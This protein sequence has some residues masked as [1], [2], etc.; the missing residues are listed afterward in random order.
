M[1]VRTL[2]LAGA[3]APLM[4][5]CGWFH[6][7]PAPADIDAAVRQA[8]DAEN[9]GPVN[10]FF[11]RPL[12][13]AADIASIGQDGPCRKTAEHAYTCEVVITWHSGKADDASSSRASLVF[14]K[15]G[16]DEWQTYGVD[17]AIVAGAAHAMVD[18]IRRALPGGAASEGRASDAS[19]R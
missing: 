1:Q 6:D 11:G 7:G 3:L 16:R 17:A 18:E 13:V 5:A 10:T 14:S 2:L 4:A 9:H 19:A 12:P 15:N 8:L